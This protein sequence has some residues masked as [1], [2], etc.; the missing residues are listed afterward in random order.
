MHGTAF[1]FSTDK[2]LWPSEVCVRTYIFAQIERPFDA[3]KPVRQRARKTIERSFG[4][5]RVLRILTG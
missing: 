3:S 2:G 4:P 5:N 1:V